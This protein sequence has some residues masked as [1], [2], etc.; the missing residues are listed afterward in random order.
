MLIA[1]TILGVVGF[2]LAIGLVFAV[3]FV[4]LGV[5]K[6]DAAAHGSSVVFRLLILPGSV[7]FWPM[8]AVKWGS[9]AKQRGNQ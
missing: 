3:A 5:G 6:V 2:Y 8:L 4:T 7:A 1:V 9:A